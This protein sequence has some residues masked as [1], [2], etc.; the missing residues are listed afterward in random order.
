MKEHSMLKR[1]ALAMFTFW[2]AVVLAEEPNVIKSVDV[3]TETSNRQEITVTFKSDLR[4]APA[5][6]AVNTPPRVALDFLNMTN[7]TGK[8]SIPVAGG[9][10]KAISLAEANGRTRMVFGLVKGSG[11]ETKID[12]NKLLVVL[13]S[14]AIDNVATV[15]NTSAQFSS[16]V[17][18]SGKEAIKDV[19]FRKG[20]AGEGRLIVDL[21]TAAVGIDIRQ[22]GKDLVLEFA[23]TS[24]PRQLERHMD[25]ADFGTAVQTVDTYTQGDSVKMVIAPRGNWEYSAYQADNRFIV[26]VRNIDEQ[27]KKLAALDKPVYKGDKLSLN[28]QSV[29]VRTVLQVIAEFTGKNIITSDTVSGNLTLRLKDVPWDQALDLILQSKGLDKRENGSVMWIAPR[30]EI[31]SREKLALEASRQVEDLEPL[32]SQSF[33][34]NYLKVDAFKKILTDEKQSILTKRGTALVEPN[35]N[36]LF[37]QDIPSRL[38]QIEK[39]VAKIDVPA[40]QVLIEARIVSASDTFGRTLGGRLALAAQRFNGNNV[41]DTLTGFNLA[42]SGQSSSSSSSSSS[43]SGSGSGT[44]AGSAVKTG[45]TDFLSQR[46]ANVNLPSAGSSGGDFGVSIFNASV[47]ALISLELQALESE[48]KGKIISSPRVV[49]RDQTKATIKQGT[50]IPILILDRNGNV[51]STYKDATLTLDVTPRITPDGRVYMELVVEKNSPTTF[52]GSTA[53]D[54]KSVNTNVL[55]GNGDTAV[56]GGIY[57]S[58]ENGTEDK[59]PLLGDVPLLGNFFKKKS[60]SKQRTELLIFITPKILPAESLVK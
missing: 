6:F 26:D 60:V 5:S 29:E 17:A 36:I 24:L 56:L 59:V 19:D 38:A 31:A 11:Y 43:G 34:L 46:N 48:G 49:A 13:D 23:K 8:T 55:V 28:F 54:T 51:S 37:V 3:K 30:D 44:G 10:L 52:N 16:A 7:G 41:Y 15:K 14:N 20:D 9:N 35:N 18:A 58:A 50:Q 40:K 42:G 21:T 53:I 39:L 12:G 45:Q 25:V 33:Q 32:R 27:A 1:I 57:E 4:A 2:A 47:G 22:Q